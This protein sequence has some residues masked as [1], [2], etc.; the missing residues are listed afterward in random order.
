MLI[1]HLK[2]RREAPGDHPGAARGRGA[3]AAPRAVKL[4]NAV[5][6]LSVSRKSFLRDE[7]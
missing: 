3:R 1:Y 6:K 5:Y 7:S 4:K 2:E